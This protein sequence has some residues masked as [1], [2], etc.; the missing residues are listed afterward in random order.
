MRPGGFKSSHNSSRTILTA[1]LLALAGALAASS[2]VIGPVNAT[3]FDDKAKET[4]T[5][6]TA[7]APDDDKSK[8]ARPPGAARTSDDDK[9]KETS[10]PGTAKTSDDDQIKLKTKLVSLTVTV[11]DPLGRFVT[12]LKKE[13]FV[14]HDDD[15]RQEI[16]HFGDEDAPITMGF[17]YDVS[18]SMSSLTSQSFL[19]LRRFFD[20]SHED[21]EYFIIAF[22][23]KP[24]LVQDF[25]ASPTEITSRVTF[26]KA[27]GSTALYDAV[28]LGIEK[29][30]QGRHKKRA[31]LLISDGEEN[32]SRYSFK[33]LRDRLK[34]SDV[35]VYSLG[36]SRYS[37]GT[38]VLE[39][40]SN[41]SGGR[42]FLTWDEPQFR[43]IYTRIAIMLRHQYVIGFYPSD[44]ERK[45]DWHNVRVSIQAP[46][47]LGRL[48]LNYK[49]QYRSFQ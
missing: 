10:K 7:K 3:G 13:N 18:G 15:V 36:I 41:S 14:V 39:G 23:S 9:S 38:G 34:E 33:E 16:A 22:N 20:T 46:K 48:T 42:T 12:G 35:A 6:G 27:K 30:N 5:P 28:Y 21:D 11:A 4:S 19:A 26:V 17:I 1:L 49:K 2:A 40:I 47:G 37:A 25:T 24:Q 43:D 8:D 44:A 45:V 29:A 31:L 32:N